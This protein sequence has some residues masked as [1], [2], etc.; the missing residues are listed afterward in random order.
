MLAKHW[1]EGTD[2]KGKKRD[3]T[4]TTLEPPLGS[5]PYRAQGLLARPHP[6]LRARS[7]T[8][9]ARTLN[10]NVGSNNFKEIRF[11]Y[12]RDSTVALGG[13]QG[14]PVD[15]RTENSAKNWATA[16]DFPAVQEKKVVL[17]EFP[18]RNFG[19][20]QAFAFNIR[21]DKF[22]DPRVRRAFNFAFD[23][24]EMNR[25]IFYGQYKR[26]D[27]YFAGTEL[28]CSGVPQGKELEIL[29]TVKDEVPAGAV[30]QALYQSGRR[31][32]AEG[33]Q[34]SARG[35]QAVPRR[36]AT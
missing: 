17:E 5:G 15:W 35:A 36:P 26:I 22:Q 32:S 20:M 1:W 14:R 18:I 30:H 19:I 2:K 28:A 24:E 25:Q 10:V 21:R 7:P 4:Q 12:Y 34:Q 23:F 8:I 33:P 27:S 29:Q 16:Y 9:G 13:L 11:E 3:I 31:Q 6:G